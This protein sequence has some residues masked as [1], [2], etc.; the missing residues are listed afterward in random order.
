MNS[1]KKE[2]KT[3]KRDTILAIIVL[4]ALFISPPII[5]LY[6]HNKDTVIEELDHNHLVSTSSD[7]IATN[8]E[9]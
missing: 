9:I 5:M 7:A 3:L 6:E 1:W 2:D 4:L 8:S